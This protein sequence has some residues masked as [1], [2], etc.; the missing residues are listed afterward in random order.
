LSFVVVQR[1]KFALYAKKSHRVGG[2]RKA[3]KSL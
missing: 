2:P 3:K 1:A